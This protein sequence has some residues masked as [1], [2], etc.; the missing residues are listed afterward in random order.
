MVA[1]AES[2]T[3]RIRFPQDVVAVCAD[4]ILKKQ[5]HVVLL[6]LDNQN[7]VIYRENM[8]KGTVNQSVVCPR[9]IFIEALQRE[10]VSIILVHNHPSGDPTPSKEDM[11]LTERLLEAG[12]L[13]NVQLLD[14]IIIARNG[15]ES[16]VQKVRGTVYQ[17]G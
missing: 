2:P 14:H 1:E 3:K 7:C 11:A 4:I 6:C 17:K 16:L 9:V 13:I 5:E 15:F 8:F 10:A 12:R